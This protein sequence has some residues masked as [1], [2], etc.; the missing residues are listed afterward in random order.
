MLGRPAPTHQAVG[1]LLGLESLYLRLDSGG[2]EAPSGEWCVELVMSEPLKSVTPQE[3]PGN[4][5]E[6]VS[7]ASKRGKIWARYQP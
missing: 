1:G 4:D 3:D 5:S 6:V 2:L 7:R